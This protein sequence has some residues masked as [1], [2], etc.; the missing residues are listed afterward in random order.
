MNNYK[1]YINGNYRVIISLKDGT[2]IRE[3]NADKFIPAFS[4]SVDMKITDRCD[5]GCPFCYEGCT[6]SGKHG[7]LNAEFLNHL[8]P[9]TELAINGND[10]THPDLIPFLKRM[11]EQKVIVS[12]T[13]NQKH[14]ERNY[15]LIRKMSMKGWIHGV[16]VSLNKATEEF[17]KLVK[18]IPNTVI[19]VINGII[20]PTEVKLLSNNGLKMLILGYKRLRRGEEY[21]AQEEN[22]IINNQQW[23]KDNLSHIIERFDVVSFDNLSIKQLDVRRLLTDKEWDEFF[24]GEDSEFTFYIDLVEKKFGKNSLATERFDLMDNIDDMFN[25]IRYCN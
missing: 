1:H 16:G 23:M 18:S 15:D 5:G 22:N 14:F 17:I 3:T 9:Y 24:M 25:K 4:E 10:L 21:Y 12:M 19:H 13:V 20:T 7:D 11:Q 8:H 6:S 2:K